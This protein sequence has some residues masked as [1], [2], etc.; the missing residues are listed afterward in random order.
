MIGASRFDGD[1]YDVGAIAI[2]RGAVRAAGCTQQAEQ[3]HESQ[4]W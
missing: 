4:A 3:R 2:A 1:Q